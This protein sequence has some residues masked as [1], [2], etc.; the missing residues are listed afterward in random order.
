MLRLTRELATG[1]VI[2]IEPGIYF[3]PSLLDRMKR[4]ALG[5]SVNWDNIAALLPRGGIRIEDNV[6][7]TDTA[8]RNLSRPAFLSAAES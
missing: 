1:F 2:T 8:A 3:I 5:R 4:T 6:L 7:V